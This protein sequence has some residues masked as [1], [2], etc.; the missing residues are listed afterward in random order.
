M[1]WDLGQALASQYQTHKGTAIQR[2]EVAVSIY[3]T[4]T[5]GLGRF[6]CGPGFGAH[7]AGIRPSLCFH[8][9]FSNRVPEGEFEATR[10]VRYNPVSWVTAQHT[11][12]NR[13]QP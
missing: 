1:L 10:C 12:L 9:T 6:D 8:F 5:C 4:S 11:G 2:E 7:L 13:A 3:E